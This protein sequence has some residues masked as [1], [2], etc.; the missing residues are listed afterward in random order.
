MAHHELG[1]QNGQLIKGFLIRFFRR[2]T[3]PTVM[4]LIDKKLA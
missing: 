3:H 1:G 4:I 2:F